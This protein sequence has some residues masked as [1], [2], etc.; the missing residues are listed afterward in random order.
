MIKYLKKGLPEAERAVEKSNVK[1]IVAQSL[2]QIES[3][4]DAAVR[5]MS[6]NFDNYVP[7]SFRLGEDDIQ[8]L[9]ARLTD[10]E[11]RNG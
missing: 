2:A 8:A 9:I 11:I 10:Q 4:G 5:E 3:K 1:D 7:N 6:Q